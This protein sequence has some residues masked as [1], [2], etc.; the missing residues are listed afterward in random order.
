MTSIVLFDDQLLGTDQ[1]VPEVRTITV[2]VRCTQTKNWPPSCRKN[3]AQSSIRLGRAGAGAGVYVP[4]VVIVADAWQLVVPSPALY[5]Y[6]VVTMGAT[7][8]VPL[9]GH[10]TVP[11]PLLMLQETNAALPCVAL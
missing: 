9:P 4:V 11:P 10:G 8:T 1:L 6:V 2:V 5:V 7:L 3:P